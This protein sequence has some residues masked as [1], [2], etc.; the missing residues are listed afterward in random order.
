MIDFGD[1]PIRHSPKADLQHVLVLQNFLD[2]FKKKYRVE[3][4]NGVP[5]TFKV[6]KRDES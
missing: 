6:T 5:I 2:E 4:F 3:V 1:P